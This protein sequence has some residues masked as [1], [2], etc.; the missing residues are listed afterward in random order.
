MKPILPAIKALT[1]ADAILA[2]AMHVHVPSVHDEHVHAPRW[3]EPSRDAGGRAVEDI[4]SRDEAGRPAP[5]NW[6]AI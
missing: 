2:G 4:A 6:D 5:L 1:E 3:D